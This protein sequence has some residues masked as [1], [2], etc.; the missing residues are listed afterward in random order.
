MVE[1][2]PDYSIKNHHLD[3][4]HQEL[5]KYVGL[6]KVII[7]MEPA[8]KEAKLKLLISKL[9]IYAKEHIKD[10]EEYMKRINY[11]F[12]KEHRAS[13]MVFMK[14]LKAVVSNFNDIDKTSVKLFEF[15]DHWLLKHIL[16]E[17]K[18]IE[19]FRNCL[20]EINELPYNLQQKTKI[21]DEA[22]DIS[23][24]VKHRYI[25]LCHLKVHEVCDTLDKELQREHSYICCTTCKN[26]II[27]LDTELEKDENKFDDLLKQYYIE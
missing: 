6:A 10:E 12:F 27:K 1:W 21:L 17:D 26:P 9:L 8:V 16:E 14:N 19:S 24:E 23:N 20:T 7:N 11:P 22:Y 3:A 18:R 4:Q 2:S 13:H 5:M 25:C 15:L